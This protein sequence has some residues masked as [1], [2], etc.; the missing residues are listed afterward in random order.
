MPD[1]NFTSWIPDIDYREYPLINIRRLG[2]TRD[3][4]APDW[5]DHPTIE[6]TAFTDV[7]LPETEILYAR[8]LEALF[9]AQKQQIVTELGHVSYVR[10]IMG[11]TKV[12]SLFQDSWRVQGLMQIGIRPPRKE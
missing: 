8:A 4:D 1:V 12:S 5:L 3:R 6:L 2:G 9:E 7:G 10:E 11:M